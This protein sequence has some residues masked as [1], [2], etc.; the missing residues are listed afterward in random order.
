MHD[1]LHH[2]SRIIYAMVCR[3]ASAGGTHVIP[4]LQRMAEMQRVP[5]CTLDMLH[6]QLRPIIDQ[7]DFIMLISSTCIYICNVS[8]PALVTVCCRMFEVHHAPPSDVIHYDFQVTPRRSGHLA[9]CGEDALVCAAG[10]L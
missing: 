7:Y 8:G 10:Y 3:L 4:L 2:S 9:S 6:H 1:V 5:W